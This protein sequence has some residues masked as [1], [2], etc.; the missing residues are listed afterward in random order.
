MPGLCPD[1][2]TDVCKGLDASCWHVIPEADPQVLD[3]LLA[4]DEADTGQGVDGGC[5]WWL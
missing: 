3:C 4:C 5:G 1:G 2:L